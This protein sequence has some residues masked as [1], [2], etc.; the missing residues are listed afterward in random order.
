M[1]DSTSA[2]SFDMDDDVE[3]QKLCQRLKVPVQ[4]KVRSRLKALDEKQRSQRARVYDKFLD[5]QTRFHRPTTTAVV[6]VQSLYRGKKA[7][8]L[9]SLIRK[10][11]EEDGQMVANEAK[12]DLAMDKNDGVH[13][14]LSTLSAPGKRRLFSR[15]CDQVNA[16]EMMKKEV[17]ETYAG[18]CTSMGVSAC[19]TSLLKKFVNQPYSETLNLQGI[20]ISALSARA[21]SFVFMGIAPCRMCRGMGYMS[22]DM[23]KAMAQDPMVETMTARNAFRAVDLDDSGF[24][25]SSE[26]LVAFRHLGLNLDLEEVEAVLSTIDE[27]Q[28]GQIDEEEFELLFKNMT[29]ES[30]PGQCVLCSGKGQCGKPCV[31]EQPTSHELKPLLQVREWMGHRMIHE[32]SLSGNCLRH[33]GAKDVFNLAL[34]C[35][36][37]LKTLR[38]ARNELGD[39]G[40]TA[41]APLFCNKSMSLTECDLSGNGIG[42]NGML[43]ISGAVRQCKSIKLLNL[44]SNAC[45]GTGCR[46]LGEMLEENESLTELDISWNGIGGEMASLFWRGLG[47]STSLIKLHGEFE[48]CGKRSGWRAWRGQWLCRGRMQAFI[49]S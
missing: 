14:V 49:D 39:D 43:Q 9:A 13:T 31:L 33:S 27:D 42:D 21:L 28:S 30:G 6:Q 29:S 32:L 22:A 8:K 20:G 4:D 41:I 1:H 3:F 5:V 12:A 36:S 46:V 17:V 35:G 40:A 44:S 7:T 48:G 10:K 38:V 47:N 18:Y 15:W 23:F 34:T 37:A 24:V 19:G 11:N 25:D 26:L 45:T 2:H 16:G